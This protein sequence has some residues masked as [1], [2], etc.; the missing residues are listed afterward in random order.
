MAG[1]NQIVNSLVSSGQSIP[2]APSMQ[3]VQAPAL[4][5]ATSPYLAAIQQSMAPAIQ[6]NL[7]QLQASLAA[8]GIG[9]SGA[10]NQANQKFFGDVNAAENSALAPLIQQGFG[11]QF[12]ANSQNAQANNS[13]SMQQYLAAIQ[14]T[15][16]TQAA[17]QA[18]SQLLQQQGFAGAQQNSSNALQSQEF[19]DQLLAS[20]LTGNAN[21]FNTTQN[22]QLGFGNQAF[23]GGIGSLLGL[24]GQ[25]L[26]GTT[27]I[28]GQGQI[29]QTQAGNL[30]SMLPYLAAIGGTTAIPSSAFSPFSFNG[31]GGSGSSSGSVFN[32]TLPG[33]VGGTPELEQPDV[34]GFM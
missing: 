25:G 20:I 22:N 10:A 15:L 5:G 14:S 2:N 16:G 21:A 31:G 9:Q 17:Q 24:N 28:V 3:Q 13:A 6:S 27:G 33:S 26:S 32:Q 18:M 8:N 34:G 30:T 23:Q 12:S 7:Q 29:G 1:I 4:S 11:Q 19:N